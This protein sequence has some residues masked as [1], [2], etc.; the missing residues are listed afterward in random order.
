MTPIEYADKLRLQLLK[1]QEENTPLLLGATTV[2]AEMHE[3]IFDRGEAAGSG[4]IGQ[5]ND[6][7]ILYLNPNDPKVY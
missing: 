6:K 4:S 2:T 3:R 7:R 5:Y 1:L